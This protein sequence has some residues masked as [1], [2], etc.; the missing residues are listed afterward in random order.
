ME[1][2]NRPKMTVGKYVGAYVDTLPNSYLRW[3]ITQKFP[4]SILDAAVKKLDESSYNDIFINVSRHALDMYSKRF[5]HLWIQSEAHKGKGGEGLATFVAKT[6]QDAWDKGVDVSK[7]R[8]D[9]DGVIK[10]YQGIKWVFGFN[11]NYPDYK[12]IITVMESND[13][14]R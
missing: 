3:L 10:E 9:D 4:T 2:S 14:C 12:E 5:I 13:E 6:A 8:H 1:N 7:H 11:Y